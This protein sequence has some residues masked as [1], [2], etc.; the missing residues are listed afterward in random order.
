M[1]TYLD[2]RTKSSK[3]KQKEKFSINDITI[4]DFRKLLKMFKNSP[5]LGSKSKQIHNDPTEDFFK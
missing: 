5:Y 4:Q 3:N 2:L 1:P